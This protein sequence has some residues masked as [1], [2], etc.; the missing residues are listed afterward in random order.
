[1]RLMCI[2]V[3]HSARYTVSAQKVLAIVIRLWP[4]VQKGCPKEQAVGRNKK[5][6]K[7]LIDGSIE[8]SFDFLCVCVF[9]FFCGMCVL[10][11]VQW[12]I[13]MVRTGWVTESMQS[14]RREHHG[15]CSPPG[16]TPCWFWP[17]FLLFDYG[18]CS[19]GNSAG[20]PES[21]VHSWSEGHGSCVTGHFTNVGHS[22]NTCRVLWPCV[23]CGWAC[24]R[25]W[26]KHFLLLFLPLKG[27][28]HECS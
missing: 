12:Q 19:L 1:M 4:L 20:F 23:L 28:S 10:S 9:T 17:G 7:P 26:E 27:H 8:C 25:R 16:P 13:S 2:N 14:W 18:K 15:A 5:Q 24:G 11:H 22:A 6:F 21:G 3:W